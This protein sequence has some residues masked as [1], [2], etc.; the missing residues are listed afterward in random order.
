MQLTRFHLSVRAF[1]EQPRLFQQQKFLRLRIIVR[2]EPIKIY[3]AGKPI[4]CKRYRVRS[5][6]SET[7]FDRL[8]RSSCGIEHD[9]RDA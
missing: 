6:S 3:A 4:R 1:D 8:N 5:G 2:C 7:V 9:D